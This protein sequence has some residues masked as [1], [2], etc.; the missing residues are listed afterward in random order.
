V[1]KEQPFGDFLNQQHEFF[2]LTD[3]QL[4]RQQRPLSF[5]A[6]QRSATLLVVPPEEEAFGEHHGSL[7]QVSC[8]LQGGLLMGALPVPPKDR[9]SDHLMKSNRFLLL[10]DCTIGLDS[11]GGGSVEATSNVL[12]NAARVIGVSEM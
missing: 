8:L 7:H 1:G 4:T 5:L 6:L 2:R 9:V 11:S 12:V 10:E 3:V